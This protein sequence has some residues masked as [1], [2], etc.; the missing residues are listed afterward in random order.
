[1]PPCLIH[2]HD[3]MGTRRDRLRYFSQMQRH[4]VGIA[5]RQPQ[6]GG[7]AVLWPDGAEDVGRFRPLV[8]WSRGPCPA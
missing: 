7:L 5:E 6:T 1:V 2:E 8:V 4:G 3:G